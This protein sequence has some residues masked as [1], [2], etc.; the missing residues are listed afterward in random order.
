MIEFL[1]VI[2]AAVSGAVI[3]E[4]IRRARAEKRRELLHVVQ[5]TCGTCQQ[6]KRTGPRRQLFVEVW[7]S[8]G[9]QYYQAPVGDGELKNSRPVDGMLLADLKDQ[10]ARVGALQRAAGL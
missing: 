1:S 4:G 3:W 8:Y 6:E 5:V 10:V 9:V 2:V 7:D